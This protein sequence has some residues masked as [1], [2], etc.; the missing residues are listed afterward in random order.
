MRPFG[1][2]YWA[3]LLIL[4]G[5]TLLGKQLL[6]WDYSVGVVWLGLFIILT[7]LSL[8]FAPKG[9][10]AHA[11][12][13][14]DS[15]EVVLFAQDQRRM[16]GA[17][18]HDLTVLFS[19]CHVDLR[20]LTPGA[21]VDLSCVFGRAEVVL[22]RSQTVSLTGNAAFGEMHTPDGRS[23]SFGDIRWHQGESETGITVE[24]NCV[25]AQIVIVQA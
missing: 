4:S 16:D 3:I 13:H 15:D 20:D 11:Y 7:G 5:A 12:F 21:H 17:G 2:L 25:F 18:E 1:K 6:P 19:D 14:V 24:A 8:L 9:P 10:S 23:V 22:S